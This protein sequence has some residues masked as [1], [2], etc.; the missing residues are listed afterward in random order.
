MRTSATGFTLIELLVVIVIIALLAGLL[1]PVLSNAKSKAQGIYCLNNLKQLQLAWWMYADDNNDKLPENRGG[2]TGSLS[3]VPGQLG[4]VA[5]WLCFNGGQ[6]FPVY[7]EDN[8]NVSLLV[9]GKFGSIGPYA[10][11]HLI[12][13][14]PGDK[15]TVVLGGRSYSRVRSVSMNEYMGSPTYNQESIT[16]IQ[17]RWFHKMTEII[18]PGP[19]KAWV[20]VDEHED[21]IDDGVFVRR[22]FSPDWILSL[23]A[24]RHNAAGGLSFADGHAEIK[25]WLDPRT[26]K[27]VEKK[28]FIGALSPGNPDVAWLQERATS[29]VNP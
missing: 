13:K 24:S 6:D 27:P 16:L 1:L 26:R 18:D 28:H 3:N 20:L 7:G 12:Y 9:P 25:K 5:G 17:E 8:T 22:L 29:P 15:T 19:S 11:S 14:C 23:P 2:L 10:K 21:S 4:W